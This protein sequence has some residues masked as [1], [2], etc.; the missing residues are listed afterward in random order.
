MKWQ[1]LPRF[2]SVDFDIAKFFEAAETIKMGGYSFPALCPDDLL[3]VLCVHAAK[4][5]WAQLSWLCD[6]AQLSISPHL[7]WENVWRQAHK[8]GLKRIVALNLFLARDL[9][10][11]DLPIEIEKYG[12]KDSEIRIVENTVLSL[13]RQG[14]DLD[15]K[16]SAYF[17]L[18]LQ[19]RER[20]LDQIR[21]L[22]RL[23][24]TPTLSDCS[25]IYLPDCIF[26][27]YHI[28]R[29]ARLAKRLGCTLRDR[30]RVP[31]APIREALRKWRNAA[32]KKGLLTE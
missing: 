20:R 31:T 6:I 5:V 4:H 15:T 23:I 2:Y 10:G 16:S 24:W 21:L 8:L 32:S 13:M 25:A 29:L 28:V 27:L 26:P 14:L 18:T 19:L 3:L 22:W 7:D 11:T 12:E 17:R 1:I 30:R 9:L